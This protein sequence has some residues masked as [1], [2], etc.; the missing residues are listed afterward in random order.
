[1]TQIFHRISFNTWHNYML[2]IEKKKL[3]REKRLAA[4]LT[5]DDEDIDR[6]LSKYVHV[7]WENYCEY[8]DK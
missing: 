3:I 8:V 1:M 2:K 7:E 6:N 5:V 4:G